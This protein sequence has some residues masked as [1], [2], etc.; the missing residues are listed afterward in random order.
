[1]GLLAALLGTT[2]AGA[3]PGPADSGGVQFYEQRVRP[4]LEQRCFAC[5]SARTPS[6]RGG[7][8]L[9]PQ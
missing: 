2:P 3:A 7:L 5:H 1:M 6:P 8:R 4:L 9:D